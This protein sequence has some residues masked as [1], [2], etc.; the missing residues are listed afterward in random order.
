M[1]DTKTLTVFILVLLGVAGA[2]SLLGV[3]SDWLFDLLGI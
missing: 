1:P 2:L 3:S